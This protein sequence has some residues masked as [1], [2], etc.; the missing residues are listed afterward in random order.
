MRAARLVWGLP[1]FRAAMSSTR[2]GDE[3]AYTSRRRGAAATLDV[4]YQLGAA[5][6]PSPVGTLEHFLLERYHLF[7]LR[8][9]RVRHGQVHHAPYPAQRATV[10]TLTQ[11]LTTAAG[12]PDDGV[13][14]TVHYAAG[15]E[16][17]VFGPHDLR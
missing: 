3:V 8:R 15:V 12:L 11:T 6:G 1:Y 5:L 13:R 4:R 17:E 10:T 9:G 7:A 16:V 14:E 2:T